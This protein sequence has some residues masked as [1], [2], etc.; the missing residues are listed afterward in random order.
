[1]FGGAVQRRRE[2]RGITGD[3]CHNKDYSLL[4]MLLESSDGQPGELDGVVDVYLDRFVILV[5]GV[6]PKIGPILLE[7]IFSI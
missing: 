7:L 5:F 1:M 3:R 4:I 2:L 6:I